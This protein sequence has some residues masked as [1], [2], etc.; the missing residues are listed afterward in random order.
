[1]KPIKILIILIFFLSGFSQLLSENSANIEVIFKKLSHQNPWLIKEPMRK[2]SLGI[3]IGEKLFFTVSLPNERPLFAEMERNDHSNSR[4]TI[5]KYDESTGF[6]ILKGEEN[7]NLPLIRLDSKNLEKICNFQQIHYSKLSFSNV[8]IRVYQ[9]D[10]NLEKEKFIVN[11]NF[12]CGYQIGNLIVPVDYVKNILTRE[13]GFEIA[14]PGFEFESSLT[15]SEKSFYFP[16]GKKGILVANVYPGVGPAFQLFPGDAIYS[17]NGVDLSKFSD[18]AIEVSALDLILRNKSEL[19]YLG[20][21]T[22][23]KFYR[24]G[25]EH[26]MHYPLRKYSD[27]EF[28]I[29]DS[30][31]ASNPPYLI[32][33]GFFFT[34]L[35][36][37]YLKEFGDNYR[38]NSEKKLLY[39]T[40]SFAGKVHPQRER[41]VILSRVLPD[42]KNIG[43]QEFQDL[44]LQKINGVDIQNLRDLKNRIK[45]TSNGYIKL[46]FSGGK[47]ILLKREILIEI[48]GNILKNYKL[49]N[50]DNLGI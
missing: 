1:M 9:A 21:N 26:T 29:P 30:H 48:D 49:K 16:S 41:I 7:F 37:A 39:L 44:I 42:E 12:L 40:E 5:E 46:D 17:I 8:P 25:K 38:K 23:L 3:R 14:H 2:M 20:K 4:L 32:S 47:T 15:S 11:K 18:S 24:N 36:T 22:E 45:T 31:P 43:Y 28:L 50:L 6:T 34:E 19:N 35:T 27:K 33:G 10:S 13:I